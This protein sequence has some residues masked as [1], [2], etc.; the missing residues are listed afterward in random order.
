MS[1]DN[2]GSCVAGFFSLGRESACWLLLFT[3]TVTVYYCY[4]ARKATPILPSRG[5]Y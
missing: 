1:A 4:T 2:Y 3:P 5:W